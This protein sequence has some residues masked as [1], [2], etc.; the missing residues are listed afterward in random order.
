MA[1]SPDQERRAQIAQQAFAYLRGRGGAR[2][3]MS[4]LAQALGM[5]RPTLY[6]YYSDIASIFEEVLTQLLQEQD[7]FVMARLV[8]IDHPIDLLLAYVRAVHEF[9]AGREDMIVFLLQFWAAGDP[10]EPTRTLSKLREHYQPRRALAVQLVESGVAA[11]QVA[12]CDARALVGL[13]GAMVDGLLIQRVIE[14]PLDLTPHYHLIAQILEPLR[15]NPSRPYPE[16]ARHDVDHA[17]EPS[18]AP[19]TRVV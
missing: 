2:V 3:T 7:G 15:R 17:Q 6:W 11:G 8:G 18:H 16:D 10:Q 12:P 9:Y 19:R 13:L 1:R 14:Q 5:K 4:E